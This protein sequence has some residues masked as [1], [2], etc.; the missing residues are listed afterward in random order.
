MLRVY[1]SKGG[2]L[3]PYAVRDI[4]DFEKQPNGDD[5]RKRQKAIGSMSKETTAWKFLASFSSDFFLYRTALTYENKF[6]TRSLNLDVGP[7][8]RIN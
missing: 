4:R 5:T 8:L 1:Y 6:F 3:L 2:Y 7:A